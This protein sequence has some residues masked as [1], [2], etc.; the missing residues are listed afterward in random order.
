ME[1]P[2]I[3]HPRAL[4]SIRTI[5]KWGEYSVSH[6]AQQIVTHPDFPK[7]IRVLGDKGKPRWM[8]GEV[9]AFF[10]GRRPEERSA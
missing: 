3:T 8:A 7:P 6:T 1:E 10:E 2:L 4:W 5:A 9:M